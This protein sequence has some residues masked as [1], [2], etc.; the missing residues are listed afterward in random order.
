[1]IEYLAPVLIAAFAYFV[2]CCVVKP[3]QTFRSYEKQIQA[4]GYK[5]YKLPF[6]PFFV[7][8]LPILKKSN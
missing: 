3:Y 8:F 1:M 4:R 5:L 2:Y 6:I 7:P